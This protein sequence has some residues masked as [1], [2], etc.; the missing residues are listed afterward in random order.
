MAWRI[1]VT[2]LI[3]PEVNR[4]RGSRQRKRG[5]WTAGVAVAAKWHDRAPVATQ[6]SAPALLP[7]GARSCHFILGMARPCAELGAGGSLL[8]RRPLAH[9]QRGADG[10]AVAHRLDADALA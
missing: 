4:P 3:S 9:L 7:S 2:S 5:R 10:L 6:G 1:R 8:G